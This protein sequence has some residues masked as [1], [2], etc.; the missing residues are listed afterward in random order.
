MT[1]ETG[2]PPE[3]ARPETPP[4]SATRATEIARL[5]LV[6]LSVESGV[7]LDAIIRRACELVAEVLQVARVG[8]WMYIDMRQTLRCVQL[9]EREKQTWSSGIVLQVADFPDYFAT[10]ENRKIVPAENATT[11]P[12]TLQL[13]EAYLIPLGI[14]SMLDAPIYIAG[15]VFGVFCSEHIGK[16]REW[17]TEERDFCAS[18]ADLLAIK[19]RAAEVM[20]LQETLR[21]SEAKM[22]AMEKS[23]ALAKMALGVAHDFRNYLTTI[24]NCAHILESA[25]NLTEQLAE[26]VRLIKTAS[27]EGCRL[28]SELID[29][30]RGQPA[31]PY[32]LNL[33]KVVDDFLPVLKTAAGNQRCLLVDTSDTFGLIFMDCNQLQRVLLNLVINARDATREGGRFASIP[34]M[35][36]NRIP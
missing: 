9:Y 10:L 4:H 6:K 23:D 22:I 33:K 24:N 5:E 16:A 35:T 17:T 34:T 28:V 36:G 20:Q 3:N 1:I 15:E 30:G 32:P 19:I 18:I 21:T 25:P 27:E 29:Y 26:S 8:V 2:L 13:S 11:D 31:N 12:K 7:S 14:T